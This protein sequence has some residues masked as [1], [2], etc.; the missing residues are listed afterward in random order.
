MANS[1]NRTFSTQNLRH[2]WQEARSR[3][4]KS[5]Y[6]SDRISGKQFERDQ[7]RYISEIRSKVSQAFRPPSL[8]SIAK[9]KPK[10]G[11]RIICVPTI[12]DRIVQFAL[13]GAINDTL[14]EK[15][16]LNNVSYG[17]ISGANRTVQD[18]RGRAAI[19]RKN[20]QWIYKA[21]I[22]KFFDNIPRDHLKQ[23]VRRIIPQRSLHPVIIPYIDSEIG[24]GFDANWQDLVSSAGIKPGVGVR[25]GMPLS[26][27]FAGMLLRDFDRKLERHRYP[28]LRYVDDI[29]AFFG[30][31]QECIDFD[32]FLRQ[33]LDT[34]GLSI[35][36]IGG[37]GSKTEI[38]RPDQEAE[39][40]GMSMRFRAN[41]DCELFIAPKTLEKIE[42]KFAEMSVIDNLLQKKITLPTLGSRL[43]SLERGY[44]AAYAGAANLGDLRRSLAVMK[45][46]CTKMVLEEILGE[47]I[48]TLNAKKRRFL[49]LD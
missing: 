35:G 7:D 1:F 5:C 47:A 2:T 4:R 49:G 15:G 38:F 25:Q 12:S 14:R 43:N 16:L 41:G 3:L 23:Q 24:D 29:I 32:G 20:R 22:E 46:Q 33:E 45:D 48:L 31:E 9:P 10:G 26:P 28:A 37:D 11:H 30:S 13:I 34:L 17:L 27:F 44:I 6:G 40:L 42:A 21:D 18:A 36:G 19:L 39:F 8:L